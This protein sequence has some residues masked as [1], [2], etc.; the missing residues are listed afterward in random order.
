[1]AALFTY[2]FNYRLIIYTAPLRFRME[3]TL[4]LA[5]RVATR[6]TARRR[7]PPFHAFI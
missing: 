5:S 3:A 2:M 4:S 6:H 7:L 1:M